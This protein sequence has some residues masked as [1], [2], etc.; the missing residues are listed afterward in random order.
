MAFGLEELH[1]D[2]MTHV[3]EGSG[4]QDG[5]LLAGPVQQQPVRRS[6]NK[7]WKKPK[8]EEGAAAEPVRKNLK[9]T[10]AAITQSI[11]QVDAEASGTPRRG[12]DAL[13]PK[14]SSGDL[15]PR[16]KATL[17]SPFL[18]QVQVLFSGGLRR[19]GSSMLGPAAS[20]PKQA[21]TP[22]EEDFSPLGGGLAADLPL[23]TSAA[24]ASTEADQAADPDADREQG[25]MPGSNAFAAK[26][27]AEAASNAAQRKGR[28]SIALGKPKS[29]FGPSPK[30]Q[31]A[32][33]S[34]TNAAPEPPAEAEAEAALAKAGTTAA[35]TL[36]VQDISQQRKKVLRSPKRSPKRPA[37]QSNEGQQPRTPDAGPSPALPS[38]T[39]LSIQKLVAKQ[40]ASAGLLHEAGRAQAVAAA[41]E[42]QAPPNQTSEFR[43]LA[44]F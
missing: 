8:Q 34:P 27:A 7:P 6:W 12:S 31:E 9:P 13:I 44:S 1:Q 35:M 5:V 11:P 42:A 17:S 14:G 21:E 38:P 10:L 36:G 37:Q 32:E 43:G 41:M 18:K 16:G 23:S 2:T 39:L 25:S 20:T 40:A 24:V 26:L 3:L 28:F 30:S 4:H 33:L 19:S 29:P 22:R 15:T